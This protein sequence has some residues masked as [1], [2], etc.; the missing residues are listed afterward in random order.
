[1]VMRIG[2]VFM[3]L[4]SASADGRAQGQGAA[5]VQMAPM[6]VKAGPLGF[7]GV[8][9]SVEMG[10]FGLV[11]SNAHIKGLVISEVLKD[12][13]AERAGLIVQD[14]ILQIDRVPVTHYT[15]SSLR[16]IGDKEKGDTIEFTV[17]GPDAKVP[18]VVQV[19]LGARKMPIN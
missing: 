6:T 12:S 11:S 7:I 17:R 14:T 3:L 18:R 15:I 4:L 19:T 8:R 9:L 5:P 16:E 10:L 2:L 13:A 1:M